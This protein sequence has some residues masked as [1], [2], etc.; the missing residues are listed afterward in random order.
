MRPYVVILTGGALP[1]QQDADPHP[2]DI[3]LA[4]QRAGVAGTLGPLDATLARVVAGEA[5]R[6]G[7]HAAAQLHRVVAVYALEDEGE[8]AWFAAFCSA[9][10]DPAYVRRA[11]SPLTAAL[12][13]WESERQAAREAAGGV[14]S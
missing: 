12:A 6:V 2:N 3:E 10:V 8:A 1:G 14:S 5:F 13:A 4:L 7:W 11:A 9:D